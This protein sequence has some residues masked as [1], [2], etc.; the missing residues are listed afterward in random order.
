M[1]AIYDIVL[2]AERQSFYIRNLVP[3]QDEHQRP[4]TPRFLFDVDDTRFP[5]DLIAHPKWMIKLEAASGPHAPRQRYWGQK[6]PAPPVTIGTQLRLPMSVQ[7]IQ[8]VPQRRQRVS[9]L[10]LRILAIQRRRQR[11]DRS[12][13]HNV[14]SRF[15]FPNPI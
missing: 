2:L 6:S 15:S 12:R 14:G 3:H 1:I 11:R 13:R 4:T 8:P 5:C 10:R 9:R 7:E